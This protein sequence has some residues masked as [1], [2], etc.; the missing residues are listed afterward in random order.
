MAP[1]T[2]RI[3]FGSIGNDDL[4][5]VHTTRLG[6]A[7]RR[8]LPPF[9][10]PPEDSSS[11]DAFEKFPSSPTRAARYTIIMRLKSYHCRLATSSPP[12][13]APSKSGPAIHV[14]THADSNDGLLARSLS[15]TTRSHKDSKGCFHKTRVVGGAFHLKS[16]QDQR[17]APACITSIRLGM[18][19]SKTHNNTQ[20]VIQQWGG[21]GG[22]GG[23]RV[24]AWECSHSGTLVYS[25]ASLWCSQGAGRKNKC[26]PQI[27]IRI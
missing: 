17:S 6:P 11:G 7:V 9:A 20:G 18:S 5:V 12:H 16:A 13:P 10:R 22:G 3:G 1:L 24:H 25:G 14:H 21:G 27:H 8:H 15:C 23:G 2:L 26:S 19:P 4:S